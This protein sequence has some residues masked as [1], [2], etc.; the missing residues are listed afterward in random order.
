MEELAPLDR[1]GYGPAHLWR[2][3]QLLRGGKPSPRERQAAESHL[4]HALDGEPEDREAAHA[5]LG[6]LYLAGGQLDPAEPHPLKAVKTKPHLRLRL[7]V[8][9]ALK[10]NKERARSEAQLAVNFY[11]A[12]SQVDVANHPARLQWADA[13]VF[14]EDFPGAV[15]ILEEGLSATHEPVYRQALASVYL[16]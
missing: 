10:G 15:A 13:T 12:R 8:L 14:L 16:V 5:L 11:R 2:A 3:V 7:A 1:L 6:E 9:Y 4:L